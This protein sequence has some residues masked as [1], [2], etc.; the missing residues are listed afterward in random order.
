VFLTFSSVRSKDRTVL[1]FTES[2]SFVLAGS[3]EG[4]NLDDSFASIEDLVVEAIAAGTLKFIFN[5]AFRFFAWSTW[6][7]NGAVAFISS[8]LILVKWS[9]VVFFVIVDNTTDTSSLRLV[10]EGGFYRPRVVSWVEDNNNLTV[11]DESSDRLTDLGNGDITE[12]RVLSNVSGLAIIFDLVIFSKPQSKTVLAGFNS[13]SFDFFWIPA[14][15]D[16]V[17]STTV[18]FTFRNGVF[19]EFSV[20]EFKA[21]KGLP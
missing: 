19:T 13:D 5:F 18:K 9:L 20:D 1:A 14:H 21:V 6:L 3:K 16:L 8:D 7:W 17:S 2:I 4:V 10:L 11:F 15:T 12:F